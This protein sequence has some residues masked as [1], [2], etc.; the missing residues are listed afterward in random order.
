MKQHITQEQWNELDK[1]QQK[2]W[3]R[4]FELKTGTT[5]NKEDSIIDYLGDY[6][7]APTIGQMIEFLAHGS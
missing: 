5:I 7:L 6:Q 1:K 2:K 4:L 3:L